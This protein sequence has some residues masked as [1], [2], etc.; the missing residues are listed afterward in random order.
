MQALEDLDASDVRDA[1][2]GPVHLDPCLRQIGQRR[3]WLAAVGA[4]HGGVILALRD[5]LGGAPIGQACAAAEALA[6]NL[7]AVVSDAATFENVRAHMA[8][9]NLIL[10]NRAIPTQI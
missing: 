3:R 9:S 4:Q 10:L 5:L 7:E 8:P 1:G 6:G 2:H